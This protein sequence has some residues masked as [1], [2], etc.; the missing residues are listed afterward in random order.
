MIGGGVLAFTML[1][2]DYDSDSQEYRFLILDPH[3]TST[4]N[5][6]LVIEKQGIAWRKSDEIFHAKNF[7]N[8]CLPQLPN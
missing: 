6:K 3:Y 8:L 1:G 4:D 2:L 7:Y 5:I